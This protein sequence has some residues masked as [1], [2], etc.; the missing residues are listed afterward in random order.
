MAWEKTLAAIITFMLVLSAMSFAQ[1]PQ[2]PVPDDNR[3]PKRPGRMEDRSRRFEHRGPGLL[4]LGSQLNITDEQREQIRA[5]V[6]RNL[7]GTK[8]QHEELAKLRDKRIAGTFT[9]DDGARAQTLREEIRAS[10]KSIHNEIVNLLTS[11]QRT[12][13]E[14][15]RQ[16]RKARHQ[17]RLQR[18][19]ELNKPE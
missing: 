7:E 18:R 3:Q 16:E 8:A 11:E 13:L 12:R 17:E 15:L 4:R 10:T 5:I 2:T 9:E 1:Q 19:Q 14:E 6:Q